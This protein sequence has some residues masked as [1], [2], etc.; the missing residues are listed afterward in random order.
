MFKVNNKNTRTT[1]WCFYYKT[2]NIFEPFSSASSVDFEQVNISWA[3]IS[4]FKLLLEQRD[5]GSEIIR[6]KCF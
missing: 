1:F 2:L 3:D 6:K 4:N 5:F